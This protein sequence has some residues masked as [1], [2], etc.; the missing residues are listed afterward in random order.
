MYISSQ[1]PQGK[2]WIGYFYL[3]NRNLKILNMRKKSSFFVRTEQQVDKI[4]E[5]G[6]KIENPNYSLYNCRNETR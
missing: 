6:T 5:E 4:I 3:Y 2:L 1:T